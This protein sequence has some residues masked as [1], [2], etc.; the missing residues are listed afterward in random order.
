MS[1]IQFVTVD[2]D[3]IQMDLI[4]NFE[5][6]LK[7]TLY[8]ADERRIFLNQ[9]VPVIVGLK[10]DINESAKQNLLRYASDEV[11]DALGEFFNVIRLSA[12]KAIVNLQYTL[13]ATQGVDVIIPSG[14][15]ATPDGLLYFSTLKDLIILA[16]QMSGNVI[17][18][19]NEGGEQY[20]NFTPGQIKTIVDPVAYV[21]SVVN[22]NTSL[23]GTNAETD[24]NFRERIRLAPESF[25]T[26]GPEGAYIYWAKTADI[27]IADISVSS[28]SP[29]AVK[30]V[31][32]MGGGDIPSQDV[33]NKVLAIVSA[34]DKRPLTDNVSTEAPTEIAYDITLTY[35]IDS[36]NSAKESTI[37]A[38][39]ESPG[40]AVDQYIAWQYGKLDRDI[41]PDYLRQ[42]MLNAG[43]SKIIITSPVYVDVGA[44]EVAKIGTQTITYG[45]LI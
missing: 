4:N 23:G 9:E 15:R 40:G 3:H 5:T 11:L 7:E 14:N 12:Q 39:I 22:I 32:L 17:A 1:E 25:S 21:A 35:Y 30:V 34:K 45:G 24:D 43:A 41:N 38:L 26:A 44:D 13:S 8:P 18:E 29:G 2:A 33:L 10:N 31:V 16:G 27:N 36:I 37:R 28:P 20:N 19:A 42:L 6:E